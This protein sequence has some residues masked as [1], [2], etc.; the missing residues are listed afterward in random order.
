[1]TLAFEIPH[2][3]PTEPQERVLT[4]PGFGKHFTD[5]MITIRWSVDAGWH[6][7]QLGRGAHSRSIRPPRCCIMPRKSSKA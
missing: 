4:D 1:M 2:P 3:K 6:D 5:H 7:A